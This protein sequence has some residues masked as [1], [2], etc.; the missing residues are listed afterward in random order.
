MIVPDDNSR[1]LL[2]RAAD[3]INTEIDTILQEVDRD[4]TST[5][6]IRTIVLE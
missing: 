6:D 5:F 3:D 4:S 1:V 2:V